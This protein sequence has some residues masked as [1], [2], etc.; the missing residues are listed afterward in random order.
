MFFYAF[1]AM[2]I[3]VGYN[4]S[5]NSFITNMVDENFVNHVC[6][7]QYFFCKTNNGI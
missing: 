3:S 4:K 7:N 1:S 6:Y 5:R 2:S